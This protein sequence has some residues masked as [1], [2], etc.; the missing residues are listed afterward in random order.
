MLGSC[1]PGS[2]FS[3]SWLLQCTLDDTQGLGSDSKVIA[4]VSNLP[5]GEYDNIQSQ[6]KKKKRPDQICP[7]IWEFS[8]VQQKLMLKSV[9]TMGREV[10]N[11]SLKQRFTPGTLQTTVE[12]KKCNSLD[13][14]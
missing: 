8:P 2:A 12:V 7:E 5:G 10:R 11:I 4:A 3:Q 14:H 6:A 1:Q 9:K 13:I